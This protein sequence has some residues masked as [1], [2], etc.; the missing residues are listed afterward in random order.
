MTNTYNKNNGAVDKKPIDIDKLCRST[1]VTVTYS[2]I[3]V[4]ASY[5]ANFLWKHNLPYC[6]IA[7]LFGVKRKVVEKW[8]VGKKKIPY[9][10]QVAIFCIEEGNCLR[11][12]YKVE[13]EAL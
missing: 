12:L 11:K 1:R 5:L 4:D 9:A 6:V 10:Y 7:K 2:D 13:R 8:V 3:C